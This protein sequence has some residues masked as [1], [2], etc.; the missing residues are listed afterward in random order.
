MRQRSGPDHQEFL[1]AL[2]AGR[3]WE[4]FV[5]GAFLRAGL[6]A[7]MPEQE[8]A[9]TPWEGARFIEQTDIL[10]GGYGIEVKTQV[11]H[12][13][14]GEWDFPFA[15][16]LLSSVK[17]WDRRTSKP[18]AF[19]V[20]SAPTRAMLVVFSDTFPE[21]EIYEAT[22]PRR[23]TKDL[24]YRAPRGLLRSFDILLNRLRGLLGQ[25]RPVASLEEMQEQGRARRRT[26][27][28]RT[29]ALDQNAKDGYPIKG[30]PYER[31][32]E[33]DALEAEFGS[34]VSDEEWDSSPWRWHGGA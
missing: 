1:Q 7:E 17:R 21:W 5:T 14:H 25:E 22:D 34:D 29:R 12:S 28:I 23:G 2:H 9:E 33:Y 6:P 26:L 20:V 13:W 18:L 15:G 31:P 11:R 3:Q 10:V 8:D 27:W 24:Y 19:V 32:S 16:I 4:A 30:K